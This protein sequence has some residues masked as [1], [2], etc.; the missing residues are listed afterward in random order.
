MRRPATDG[1]R[2]PGRHR[3][4]LRRRSQSTAPSTAATRRPTACAN[5]ASDD[6][7][8]RR[9]ACSA[10]A[11]RPAI[12]CKR[13][14]GRHRRSTCDDDRR[15][16]GGQR[17]IPRR[18]TAAPTAPNDAFC[19]DADVLQRRRDLRSRRSTARRAPP[20]T[21]DD[22][23]DCTD[24]QSAIKA[25]GCATTPPT[26]RSCDDGLSATASRPATPPTGLPGRHAAVPATTP[27]SCTVDSCD[28][29]TDGCDNAAPDD[30]LRRRRRSATAPR[31][32][33]AAARLP[34]GA[35]AGSDCD[36]DRRLHGRR[37]DEGPDA[38]DNAPNDRPHATTGCSATA[39]RPA[40]PGLGCQAG[41]PL[42]P[43]T[44][45]SPARIDACDEE[46]DSL[47]PTCRTTR[48]ATTE[49]FC[50]GVETLRSRARLPGRHADRLRRR[51]RG[52]H[53]RQS[54]TRPLD[55]VRCER[56]ERRG[57]R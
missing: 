28:E 36:D 27:S 25:T 22:G 5:T 9:R 38:C 53:R 1:S 45:G 37:C 46:T 19:D 39:A 33:I 56:S 7:L 14:P 42:D 16:H 44:T 23:V 35:L 49:L 15:L 48:S 24:R 18:P 8:L 57:L 43:K 40:I 47:R 54:V 51:H 29:A 12:P 2:L 17:A 32:A 20:P 31:P 10:T 13:L 52:L 26:T 41:A 21:C 6:G 30:S 4:G 11:S 34:G 50:N 55:A 3:A